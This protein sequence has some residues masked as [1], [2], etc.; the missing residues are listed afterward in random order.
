MSKLELKNISVEVAGVEVVHDAS[1][2]LEGGTLVLLEGKNGSGKSSLVQAVIGHPHY[3]VTKGEIILDGEAITQL[4]PHE[5]A[6]RG[7]FLSFQHVPKVGG[8]TLATFLH[9][10]YEAT[11]CREVPALQFYLEQKE[12]IETLNLN[13]ALL[14]KPVTEGLSGGERKQS[15]LIQLVVLEPRFALLDE[16]DS[17]VDQVS[18]HSMHTTITHLTQM[19]TGILMI[20]HLPQTTQTLSFD[21]VSTMCDGI[22]TSDPL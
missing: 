5:K 15:E 4:P 10:A 21:N 9:K 19:G 18:I 16:L 1:L 6:K 11:H 13:A 12:R 22:V 14:D 20:S 7:L 2:T 17:G 8:V 3:I